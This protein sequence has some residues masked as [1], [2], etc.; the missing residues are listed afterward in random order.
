MFLNKTQIP[1]IYIFHTIY[2]VDVGSESVGAHGHRWLSGTW[3]HSAETVPGEV[4]NSPHIGQK[5]PYR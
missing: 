2:F 5:T 4:P 1:C 3:G